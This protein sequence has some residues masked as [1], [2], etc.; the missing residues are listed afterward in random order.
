MIV[1]SLEKSKTKRLMHVPAACFL[2]AAYLTSLLL[3]SSA[4][5]SFY[6]VARPLCE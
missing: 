4:N 3:R 1:T 6:V 2:R 5:G